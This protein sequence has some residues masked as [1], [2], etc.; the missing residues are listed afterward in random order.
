MTA[1]ADPPRRVRS[2]PA[3][4]GGKTGAREARDAHRPDEP[5]GMPSKRRT[6]AASRPG[7][8]G[9]VLG[10]GND[11]LTDDAIGPLIVRRLRDKFREQPSVDFIESNE[12]GLALLDFLEGYDWALLVD[13][14]VSGTVPPATVR[15]FERADFPTTRGSNPHHVGVYDALAFAERVDL[16]VP[17]EIRVVAIEVRDPFTFGT[18]LTPELE[19]ASDRLVAEVGELVRER[20]NG[21]CTN[22]ES[23]KKSRG[24]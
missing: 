8:R 7:P 16:A 23:P 14:I 19:R 18:G 2:R 10:L 17:K 12:M 15:L 4:Y 24:P 1:R 9:V 13:S 6:P 3:Q 11:I 20:L 21:A 5:E 22:T